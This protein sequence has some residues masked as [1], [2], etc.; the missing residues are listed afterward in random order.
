MHDG[1]ERTKDVELLNCKSGADYLLGRL[2]LA[3]TSTKATHELY[4]KEVK[5]DES[6]S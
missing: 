1:I 5:S 6:E 2:R 4:S 3:I